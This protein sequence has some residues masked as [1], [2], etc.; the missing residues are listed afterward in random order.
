MSVAR[1]FPTRTACVG[2]A[3]LVLLAAPATGQSP[4]PADDP[5][6]QGQVRPTRPTCPVVG[7]GRLTGETR[8]SRRGPTQ[9]V[10]RTV[11]SASGSQ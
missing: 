6:V 7:V 8:I 11:W 4:N 5:D 1:C 2:A 10:D 3:V 9:A